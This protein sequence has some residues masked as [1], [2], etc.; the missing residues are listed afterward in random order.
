M[1]N[2]SNAT[3]TEV[4]APGDSPNNAITVWSCELTT[5]VPNWM[6]PLPCSGVSLITCYTFTSSV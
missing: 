6:N 1:L 3:E 2:T 5:S 4:E